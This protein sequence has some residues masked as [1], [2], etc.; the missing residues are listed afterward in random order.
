MS[1]IKI[2]NYSLIINFFLII[3]DSGCNWLCVHSQS[4]LIA[5]Y[6]KYTTQL[7]INPFIAKIRSVIKLW[8]KHCRIWILMCLYSYTCIIC[9]CMHSLLQTV[10][11]EQY[12]GNTLYWQH[13][14]CRSSLVLS[15]K[16]APSS[17]DKTT[18]TWTVTLCKLALLILL[19]V[20]SVQVWNPQNRDCS[21]QL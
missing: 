15:L 14:C 20:C 4:A 8:A 3:L 13:V 9:T 1:A 19:P 11:Q 10:C 5:I 16:A 6:W 17:H 12:R 18:W 21:V 7:E 2:N